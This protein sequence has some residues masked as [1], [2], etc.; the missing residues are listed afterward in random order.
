[1]SYVVIFRC[2]NA[3]VKTRA[4]AFRLEEGLYAYVG[5]CGR[6]CHKRISR[7]LMRPSRKFW[8]VDFLPCEALLA[9]ATRLREADLATRLAA[10]ASYIVGFGS[11]DDRRAPSHLFRIPSLLYLLDVISARFNDQS[12]EA[13]FG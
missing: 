6:S 11:S 12:G 13:D 7:H 5:S 4:R 1:M 8:H 9:L 10:R 2:P 3:L